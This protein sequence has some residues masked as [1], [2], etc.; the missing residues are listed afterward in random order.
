MDSAEFDFDL[1]V[2]LS[3]VQGDPNHDDRI[4]RICQAIPQTFPID[5]REL[6]VQAVSTAAAH[7]GDRPSVEDLL[8]IYQIDETKVAPAPLRIGIVGDVLT[9]GTHYRAMHT[10]FNGRFPD[11]PIVGMFIARQVFL[12]PFAR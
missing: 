8:N 6:V 12:S 2:E 11:V 7:E 10:I 9:A 1:P 5:V 4:V 3:K